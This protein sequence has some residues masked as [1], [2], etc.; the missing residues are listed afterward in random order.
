MIYTYQGEI[1]IQDCTAGYMYKFLMGGNYVCLLGT[2]VPNFVLVGPAQTSITVYD[3]LGDLITFEYVVSPTR[4]YKFTNLTTTRNYVITG[5]K[6]G[7]L[8]P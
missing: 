4:G 1:I 3:N 7:D 6:T 5:M 8:L 2:T